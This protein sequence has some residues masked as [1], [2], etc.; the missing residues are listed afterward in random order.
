MP[1][2]GNGVGCDELEKVIIYMCGFYYTLK[3]VL[4][5]IRD[6]IVSFPALSRLHIFDS[7]WLGSVIFHGSTKQ[8]IREPVFLK[9]EI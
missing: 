2:N 5:V 7:L 8:K 6:K 4:L 3:N 1:E 9:I